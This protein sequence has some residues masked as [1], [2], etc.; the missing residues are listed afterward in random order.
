[1]SSS[2]V[3]HSRAWIKAS[4]TAVAVLVAAEVIGARPAAA[5]DTQDARQLVERARMTIDSFV[6]DESWSETLRALV[7]KARG[8][9][10]FPQVLRGAF[11]FGGS[12]GSEVLLVRDSSSDTWGGPAFYTIGGISFGAQAGGDASEVV[13]VALTDRGVSAF[14]STSAKLGA[15]FSI[16]V[17]PVGAG[18]TGATENIS[19]DIV[20]YSRNKGLYAGMSLEGAIMTTRDSLNNA[21]YGKE[22]TPTDI[23]INHSVTNQEAAALIQAVVKVAGGRLAVQ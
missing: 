9:L 7:S 8:V 17:G 14:L 1:M 16:A 2:A 15:N 6:A 12:G 13:L 10:I 11:I 5:D 3:N 22:G 21:F 20:S 19:A 23:L 18:V 4:L